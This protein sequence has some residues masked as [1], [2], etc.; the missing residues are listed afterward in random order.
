MQHRRARVN[1]DRALKVV[2][3]QLVL[4]LPKVD[5]PETKPRIVVAR[6]DAQRVPVP[7]GRALEILARDVFVRRQGMSVRALRV[8]LGRAPKKA[9]RQLVFALRGKAIAGGE[10]RVDRGRLPRC[11][12][13]RGGTE[14]AH[15]AADD[16]MQRN[17]EEEK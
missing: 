16:K 6:V 14:R 5:E 7:R 2:D 8:Q 13:E 1:A 15:D 17:K 11:A 3:G 9:Q 4:L 10:A 12:R